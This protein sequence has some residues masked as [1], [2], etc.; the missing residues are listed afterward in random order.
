MHSMLDLSGDKKLHFC[1]N[2][3][4]QIWYC[5]SI[6]LMYIYI[7]QF[8]FVYP[9]EGEFVSVKLHISTLDHWTY[10]LKIDASYKRWFFID[11]I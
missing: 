9:F 5:V 4:L 10:A 3:A 6:L 8:E 11:W 7:A 2:S 1:L